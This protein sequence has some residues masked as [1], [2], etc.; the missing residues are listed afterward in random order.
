M[1][2]KNFDKKGKLENTK[3]F[4]NRAIWFLSECVVLNI[5]FV[6]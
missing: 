5:N 2:I 4:K 6:V 1:I 3:Y